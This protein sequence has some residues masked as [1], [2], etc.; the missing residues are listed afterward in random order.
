MKL[1]ISYPVYEGE[2]LLEYA[3]RPIRADVAFISVICQDISFFGNPASPELIPT[4]QRLQSE[5]LIDQVVYERPD[6]SLHNKV[7]ETNMR[8]LGLRLSRE[9][10]CT[11]H[12]SADV[13]EMYLP[14]QLRHVMREAEGYDCTLVELVNYYRRPTY[15]IVPEQ[16]H[17]VTFVHPVDVCYDKDVKF[18]HVVEV[19]RRLS[20]WD[21]TRVFRP[22]ELTVHHMS[23]VRKDIR[24]KLVNA[25]TKDYLK[26][27]RFVEEF[28]RYT[29]GS[30]LCI[31][32]EFTNRRTVLPPFLISEDGLN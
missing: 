16:R 12:I 4:I 25:P 15:K 14:D 1:G 6:L 18:P 27:D 2:E 9:S 26:V 11:H 21:K 32:P 29:V 24:R 20:R 28:S 19:S 13:D 5:G 31:P 23:Y 3:L 22:E 10:G 8:N 17:L 30:R 7:N